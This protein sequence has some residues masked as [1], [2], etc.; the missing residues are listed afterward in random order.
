MVVGI[1]RSRL[2]EEHLA[3][4]TEEAER[5]L[6]LAQ[7]MPGFL[8]MEAF[9]SEDGERLG[10]FA[11]ETIEHLDAWRDDPEHQR[12]QLRGREEF[13]SEYSLLVCET[14]RESRFEWKA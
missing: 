4:Y 8:S 9:T 1:F 10:L 2:R 7:K 13:Y 12:T 3:A 5:M 11:F 14:L 6:A